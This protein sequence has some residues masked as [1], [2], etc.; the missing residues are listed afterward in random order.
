MRS[1]PTIQKAVRRIAVEVIDAAID[2]AR[3][4]KDGMESVHVVRVSCKKI[5]GLLRL[6]D[7]SFDNH[8]IENAAFRDIAAALATFREADTHAIML[9]K[10]AGKAKSAEAQGRIAALR[11]AIAVPDAD[12]R[13]AALQG[14]IARLEAARIRAGKWALDRDGFAAV[15]HGLRRTA[16]RCAAR[17][18]R[19]RS[20]G[21][22]PDFHVWRKHVKY[23]G[24]HVRLLVNSAPGWM[25]PRASAL[26]RL[27]EL[28]GEVHDLS[29]FGDAFDL[30]GESA[31]SGFRTRIEKRQRA[32]ACKALDLG[33]ILFEE[34]AKPRVR[35]WG[36][37]W[38]AWHRSGN[39]DDG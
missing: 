7:T 9:K 24:Y 2:A 25:E 1:D 11:Q 21:T 18:R 39:G 13:R 14:V 8:A 35:R 4:R 36:G 15:E 38:S 19:V 27:G 30:P 10:M 17:L 22:V 26:E 33:S 12:I 23:H 3:A 5:R 32:I 31:S 6:V 29:L 16:A 28:L 37:W 34:P 20:A